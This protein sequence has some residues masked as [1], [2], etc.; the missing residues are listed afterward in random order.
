M[1]EGRF[2]R[3]LE[4]LGNVVMNVGV[5]ALTIWAITRNSAGSADQ[6]SL[7]AYFEG[8]G[9]TNTTPFTAT[10]MWQILWQG[11]LEISVNNLDGD[12]AGRD[13]VSGTN[14]AAFFPTPGSFFLAIASR[15][16]ERWAIC[17]APY[18]PAA[19]PPPA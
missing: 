8:D 13:H 14:G 7:I 9:D 15:T 3:F 11:D 18:A 5:F 10:G 17:V 16:A 1:S 4:G 12:A 6:T 2:K 19:D